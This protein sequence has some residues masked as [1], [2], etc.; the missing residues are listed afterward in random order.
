MQSGEVH[1][2]LDEEKEHCN[3]LLQENEVLTILK[4][5]ESEKSP[6]I[7]GLLAEFYKVLARC[8]TVL[9]KLI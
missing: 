1:I 5:L 4:S 8:S 6:G 9:N 3:G 2:L 7:D